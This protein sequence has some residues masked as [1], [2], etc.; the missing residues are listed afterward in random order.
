MPNVNALRLRTYAREYLFESSFSPAVTMQSIFAVNKIHE[1]M[2]QRQIEMML[3]L[4]GGLTPE[5]EV[6]PWTAERLELALSLR[7]NGEKFMV[8]S[9]GTPHKPNPVIHGVKVYE[10]LAAAKY[11]YRRGVRYEDV[12]IEAD[13]LDTIGNAWFARRITDQI[14]VRSLAVVTSEFH[15]KRA[16]EAFCA[17]FALDPGGEQYSL[18]FRR[19][20]D[21]GIEERA[22]NARRRKEE[23]GTESLTWQLKGMRDKETFRRWLFTQHDAYAPGRSCKPVDKRALA[24][25]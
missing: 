18:S 13:S 8:L 7:R 25:Y 10:S 17:V 6:P 15:W 21:V 11:L 5:G 22:L 19:S 3:I 9:A 20:P 1:Q 12:W 4:G 24:T 23:H 2:D 16:Q 14:G